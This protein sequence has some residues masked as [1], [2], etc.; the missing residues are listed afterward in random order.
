MARPVVR[1]AASLFVLVVLLAAPWSAAEAEEGREGE[2][3]QLWMQIWDGLV[4]IWSDI[5]CGID[6]HG[7]CVDNV[8]I[9]CGLDPNGG[10]VDN[11]PLLSNTDI[12]CG[13]DPNGRCGS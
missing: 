4:S 12:G 10:C 2:S 3:S 8:D 7:G 9:G 11:S 13:A 1:R 6:P 5:G